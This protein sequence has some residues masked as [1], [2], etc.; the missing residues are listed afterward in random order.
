M[1]QPEVLFRE[2]HAAKTNKLP[3][4]VIC[5]RFVSCSDILMQVVGVQDEGR[6]VALSSTW[7]L[8]IQADR[9][10]SIATCG[11]LE[12]EKNLEDNKGNFHYH[13]LEMTHT[14]PIQISLA[15]TGLMALPICKRTGKYSYP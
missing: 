7:S 9:G 8:R 6:A 10:T 12:Q 15:R 4:L 13:T 3:D 5:P 14:V 2:G 11:L 1:T